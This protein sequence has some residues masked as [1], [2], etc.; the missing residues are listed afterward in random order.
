MKGFRV[1]LAALFLA[2]L[3]APAAQGVESAGRVEV[4]D[5]D[6]LRIGSRKIRLHG[7]DAPELGQTCLNAR[8]KEW[9]CGRWARTQLREIVAGQ[10]V[11]CTLRDTDR[12]GRSIATCHAN[13]RDIAAQMAERGAAVAFTRFSNDYVAHET[14]AKR[15]GLGL[16]A[17]KFDHPEAWRKA[18]QT[19]EVVPTTTSGGCTIKGNISGNGRIYHM[20]G[21]RHY[22]ETSISTARGERWFCTEAEARAA[23]WR[24]AR[25]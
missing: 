4:S 9:A 14:R 16:W 7:I 2:G 10:N 15:A 17:G 24:R 11:T 3:A 25:Q 12:Y 22:A 8:S 6:S 19:G 23:G 1:V 18:R 13:G 20:P 21:Q 5:G